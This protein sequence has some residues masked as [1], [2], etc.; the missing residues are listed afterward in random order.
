VSLP[1]E[2]SHSHVPSVG[3]GDET[4]EGGEIGATTIA[5]VEEKEEKVEGG[6]I[7]ATPIVVE[8]KEEEEHE[9]NKT[10]AKGDSSQVD[11][12]GNTTDVGG[13]IA[14][15]QEMQKGRVE[16]DLPVV[17]PSSTALTACKDS[18]VS[19]ASTDITTD[20]IVNMNE[21]I[22]TTANAVAHE[23]ISHAIGSIREEL[24]KSNASSLLER[25]TPMPLPPPPLSSCPP[26]PPNW[27]ELTAPDSGAKYY[28]NKKTGTTTWDRPKI[29][30]IHPSPPPPF[31]REETHTNV[32][33][34]QDG[35]APAQQ[36]RDL[37]G[38]LDP[39]ESCRA[40]TTEGDTT[41]SREREPVVGEEDSLAPQANGV[42]G[43][44]DSSPGTEEVMALPAQVVQPTA[45]EVTP[46]APAPFASEPPVDAIVNRQ[47][48]GSQELVLEGVKSNT[49]G[50]TSVAAE[51]KHLPAQ[52]EIV[53]E[54][55][56]DDNQNR[57][58]LPNGWVKLTDPSGRLYYY[59]EATDDATWEKP[60]E[61]N[62]EDGC[63]DVEEDERKGSPSLVEEPIVIETDNVVSKHNEGGLE[64]DKFPNEESDLPTDWVEAIDPSSGKPYY[65]NAAKSITTWEK[66]SLAPKE[67]DTVLISN[68]NELKV[69]TE[70]GENVQYIEKEDDITG[71][72]TT[73]HILMPKVNVQ[74]DQT[75]HSE[76]QPPPTSVM[77]AQRVKS[78]V[79]NSD[80]N[81]SETLGTLELPPNDADD[82][83]DRS[84]IDPANAVDVNSQGDEISF[85]EEDSA[86]VNSLLDVGD[87]NPN[88]NKSESDKGAWVN[89]EIE[90]AATPND[91]E[92]PPGW[93]EVTDPASGKPYYY[94]V[95]ENRTTWENPLL[96]VALPIDGDQVL[97]SSI[98]DLMPENCAD[99]DEVTAYTAE[100]ETNGQEDDALCSAD[101]RWTSESTSVVCVVALEVDKT[102]ENSLANNDTAVEVSHEDSELPPGWV[103]VVDRVSGKSFYFNELEGLSMW[104]KPLAPTVGRGDEASDINSL[105][106]ED[107]YVKEDAAPDSKVTANNTE[108]E[109]YEQKVSMLYSTE[110]VRSSE[111]ALSAEVV[112]SEVGESNEVSLVNNNKA[113]EVVQSEIVPTHEEVKSAKANMTVLKDRDNG[114]PLGIVGNAMKLYD[115]DPSHILDVN[116]IYT[117]AICQVTP[118]KSELPPG[119]VEQVD[120]TSGKSFY[121]NEL[122][123]LSVWEKPSLPNLGQLD[124]KSDTSR[125]NTTMNREA[126]AHEVKPSL[127]AKDTLMVDT[128]MNVEVINL[129]AHKSTEGTAPEVRGTFIEGSDPLVAAESMFDL[130]IARSESF[131]S[132]YQDMEVIEP[133]DSR[134][135]K[136]STINNV[137][138]ETEFLEGSELP[139]GWVEVI[140]PSSGKPYYHNK[141]ENCTTWDKPSMTVPLPIR[142]DTVLVSHNPDCVETLEIDMVEDKVFVHDGD[143]DKEPINNINESINES[144]ANV[145]DKDA[146]WNSEVLHPSKLD[147]G[148]V[149]LEGNKSNEGPSTNIEDAAEVSLGDSELP[150]GWVEVMDPSSGKPYYY[151]VDENRTTWDKPSTTVPLPIVLESRNPN[152]A[153]KLEID[154]VEDEVSL[155]VGEGDK[156]LVRKVTDPTTESEVNTEE[157]ETALNTENLPISTSI[158]DTGVI[159][160]EVEKT[161]E[162]PS[163]NTDGPEVSL[164]DSELPSGWAEVNDPSS[165]KPYY[166][167]ELK[168]LS[169]WERPLVR[170]RAETTS[171]STTHPTEIA[172]V[173]MQVA[174]PLI[175][176]QNDIKLVDRCREGG[177]L[178]ARNSLID[179]Q[180]HSAIEDNAFDLDIVDA[181]SYNDN[182]RGNTQ[183][184]EFAEVCSMECE[185]PPGWLEIL[186]PTGKPYYYNERKGVTTWE[187]PSVQPTA[188]LAITESKLGK[189][190]NKDKTSNTPSIA[191]ELDTKSSSGDSNQEWVKVGQEVEVNTGAS[192]TN[193]PESTN[194]KCKVNKDESGL[195]DGHSPELPSGW[196]QLVDNTS[197]M[198]YFYNDAE[199]TSTWEVPTAIPESNMKTSESDNSPVS[200]S[201]DTFRQRPAH[202]IASF[203]FGGKLCVMIPQVA[204]RLSYPNMSGPTTVPATNF[205]RKGPVLIHRLSSMITEN[206]SPTYFEDRNTGNIE[207]LNSRSD[208]EV[209][210]QI[211][212]KAGEGKTD[213]ELLWSLI[214]IAARWNGRLRSTLGYSDPHGPEAAIV[215]LLLRDAP[216]NDS[217]VVGLPQHEEACAPNG[218]SSSLEKV[219]GFLLRGQRE[220]AVSSALSSKNYALALLLA[221]MCSDSTYQTVVRRYADEALQIG[222]PLHTV[223]TLFAQPTDE[224][225]G[226]TFDFWS[227][228][229][230]NLH[231]TWRYHLSTILSNQTRGWKKIVISLGDQ[232]LSLG[233]TC[234][235]HF[236]YMVS[237]FSLASQSDPSARLVLVGC[238]HSF[239]QHVTLLSPQGL[240]SYKRTE[241]FEWS[242]QKGNPHA[243]VVVFQPFK[244]RY[245]MLLA[246]HGFEKEAKMYVDNIR[247]CTG[248]DSIESIRI[249]KKAKKPSMAYDKEFVNA[250]NIFDDRLCK[251]LGLSPQDQSWK[252]G[253][254]NIFSKIVNSNYLKPGAVV[255]NIGDPMKASFDPVTKRCVFPN[256]DPVK[257]VKVIATSSNPEILDDSFISAS[258]NPNDIT[259]ASANL[260]LNTN[261]LQLIKDEAIVNEPDPMVVTTS[262]NPKLPPI[263]LPSVPVPAPTNPS[264]NDK[265]IPNKTEP[266]IE[267]TTSPKI[268]IPPEVTIKA[269]T[270]HATGKPPMPNSKNAKQEAPSSGRSWAG[271]AKGLLV[272]YLNPEGAVTANTGDAMEAFFDPVT[273]RWVFPNDDPVNNVEVKLLPPPTTIKVAATKDSLSPVTSNN[274]LDLL[275]APPSHGSAVARRTPSSGSMGPPSGNS[276]GPPGMGAFYSKAGM[277]SPK[278]PSSIGNNQPVGKPP[279][280]PKF[281]IFQP[282]P[283]KTGSDEKNDIKIS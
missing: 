218:S 2:S 213:S 277:G 180:D 74:E 76:N 194:I 130:G 249:N 81:I 71:S 4:D 111:N 279:S 58:K 215:N 267:P 93:E 52:T 105:N 6:H 195:T 109:V 37:L 118:K 46:N 66:P 94:N 9:D 32:A 146:V 221:G 51:I 214:F 144:E 114:P 183:N 234:A 231:K 263:I 125:S 61:P 30:E 43:M 150:S 15:F 102:N 151:N 184:N 119:W 254:Q 222:S 117:D 7:G 12:K 40:V 169:L 133:V 157:N 116:D 41:L 167:N 56:V 208:T 21:T 281:T 47:P 19:T 282:A 55:V 152:C 199:N 28:F 207:P 65:Y 164:E 145:E 275:M 177:T 201:S 182:N 33:V 232:L 229:S 243:T 53:V 161:N 174:E 85:N 110:N 104:E 250:L 251:S 132:C 264:I 205:L 256:D 200:P 278:L 190:L 226:S 108:P 90:S 276:M 149:R 154:M 131:N 197:G 246:D 165:G 260:V 100:P 89:N 158:L 57:D 92:L 44:V 211:K 270:N 209:M 230:E 83:Q 48:Q 237:G 191:E 112:A 168:G 202:A 248:L 77:N 212:Q 188:E 45:P 175:S 137:E 140:D 82:I 173:N 121:F 196:V 123:G 153:E 228:S 253:V 31:E 3:G 273:K 185:L 178:E 38:N 69:K 129:E 244:L 22:A 255:T 79:D 241:A 34:V 5:V 245:A 220:D 162:G 252:S 120:L 1:M 206:F 274:P 155:H 166:F 176:V 75:V 49:S 265:A 86:L 88:D 271:R 203:G 96:S 242:K 171:S 122:E 27:A 233:H 10:W 39:N 217:G 115:K 257:N 59:N 72:E 126:N 193:Q 239:S 78:E 187:N 142:K 247:K 143:G 272:S 186:D 106:S 36:D 227:G 95:S 223:A 179:E 204:E 23:I 138:E 159:R 268:P 280:T 259:S 80:G 91:S 50:G 26:L 97:G 68:N 24:P 236:C 141:A 42:E 20:K 136:G 60:Y 266:M 160:L 134:S 113:A 101:L 240:E 283:A 219:Q 163:I 17:K 70:K 238:D 16:R 172:Q 73:N 147:A 8:E 13:G 87:I 64:E 35:G 14:G 128:P 99:E 192:N 235:A 25:V 156:V 269:P 139:P 67:E 262:L 84:V 18:I 124:G 148:D 103:E 181:G 135:D 54:Q 127:S 98:S 107:E 29:E 11:K 170:K 224:A 258:S 63:E 189:Q 198:T 62:P 225:S 216:E 261:P 210:T